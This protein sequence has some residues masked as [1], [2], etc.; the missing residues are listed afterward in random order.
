MKMTQ[1]RNNISPKYGCHLMMLLIAI[2]SLFAACSTT[3]HLPEGEILYS[4]LKPM[5]VTMSDTVDV[6]IKDAVEEIL[7]V[8]PNS[9]LFGSAYRQSPFPFGLWIYNALYTEKERGLR[10]WIWSKFKSDPTLISQVNPVLRCR[11]AEVAMVDEGYFDG[12]VNYELVESRRN[13]QRARIRYS[14]DYGRHSRLSDVSFMPTIDGR[15]D[16]VVGH[17]AQEC[18]LKAGKRFSATDLETERQRISAAMVD[19]GYYFYRPEFVRYMADTTGSGNTVA[20]RVITDFEADS[21]ELMPCRMD[22]V[23]IKLDYGYAMSSTNFVNDEGKTIAYRGPLAVKP[24]YLFDCMDVKKGQPYYSGLSDNVVK[25]LA[26]LNTFKYNSVDFEPMSYGRDS[27][28]MMMRIFSTY[29]SPWNGSLEIK[30][31]HK[32]NNQVGPGLAFV[33]QKRNLLGGGELLRLEFNAGYEWNTGRH[34]IG[35]RDGLLNSYDFGGRV[36]MAVPRL[37]LPFHFYHD[38]P[39]TTTY[40]VSADV[41]RRSGFFQMMK[42]T[43]ELNYSFASDKY[44]SHVLT[45]LQLSY[46]SLISKTE[47]FDAIVSDNRVLKQ[48]FADQFIPSIRYSYL[49]DN[50]SMTGRRSHQWVQFSVAEAGGL[51]DALFGKI[52][53]HRAQGERQFLWQKF[54]QFVKTSIDVRNYLDLGHRH[55]LATRLYGGLAYAYGN[56]TTI[57]YSEQFYIGGANSLRGFS[58]RG[59]GP[60]VFNPG[61]TKYSYMDRTGD[62]K[63]E[64][65]IEWRFPLSGD[66]NAALFADAGNIWT[67]RNEESRK[68]GQFGT[69]FIRQLATDCGFGVRYDF[70]MILVRFDVGVPV[71]DPAESGKGYYNITGSFFGNLGYH[72]AVGY[73]F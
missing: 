11:A 61:S 22:S 59:I 63:L 6:R 28:S 29:D 70:G 57:P 43:L 67:M 47:Q 38:L 13:P 42:A 54:S 31:A 7:E 4:G 39:V 5:D 65:N 21:T 48:S 69:S 16:S 9:S 19:S 50:S 32:D 20:L 14:V 68:G 58:I 62:V 52:G 41:M 51:L 27:V 73:P 35:D 45:P 33:A 66:F 8:E 72:L 40:S 53:S 24:K 46:T 64:A 2:M 1:H 56:S 23:V 36:S 34:S 12:K 15:I 49:Y 26:R 30:A 60:G 71:H 10:H 18:V 3:R 44:S 55:V 25:R 37:Q 17:I